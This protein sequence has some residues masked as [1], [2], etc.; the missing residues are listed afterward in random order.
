MLGGYPPPY[1]LLLEKNF[2]S[3]TKADLECEN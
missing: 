3:K 2:M 1:F